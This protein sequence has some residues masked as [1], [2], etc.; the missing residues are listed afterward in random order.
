MGEAGNRLP[1]FVGMQCSKPK[2]YI[3]EENKAKIRSM[4]CLIDNA[5]CCLGTDP[6]HVKTRGSGGG[7]ELKQ[8]MPLCR[9][10]HVEVG[11]IGVKT[12]IK[13]YGLYFDK[14]SKEWKRR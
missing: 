9:V 7:D 14:E 11:T 13:K 8:L 12:F 6:H 5:K 2:R 10:H 3:S 1:F 4:S